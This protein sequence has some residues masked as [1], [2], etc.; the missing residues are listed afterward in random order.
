MLQHRR[1]GFST[2]GQQQQQQQ[3]QPQKAAKKQAYECQHYVEKLTGLKV[4]QGTGHPETPPAAAAAAGHVLL[5]LLCSSHEPANIAIA[6][7]YLLKRYC[8]AR[9]DSVNLVRSQPPRATGSM[10][11]LLLLLQIKLPRVSGIVLKE[12]YRHT[13]YVPVGEAK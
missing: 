7:K 6:M 13:R 1:P 9:Q 4:C 12:R 2:Q 10:L 8:R 5:T 11:L 3:Q